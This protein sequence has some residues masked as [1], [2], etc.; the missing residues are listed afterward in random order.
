MMA[1]RGTLE[2]AARGVY[3]FPRLP[4]GSRDP[5]ML[6]VLWAGRRAHLSHETALAV[7]DLSDLVPDRVHVTVPRAARLRRSGGELYVV[8]RKD[9]HDGQ[10]TWW[11]GIPIVTVATA[12]RQCVNT[13]VPAYLLRQAIIAA[14]D[15]GEREW[16]RA[17]G[18][19]SRRARGQSRRRPD[20]RGST[21]PWLGRRP[22]LTRQSDRPQTRT[23]PRQPMTPAPASARRQRGRRDRWRPSPSEARSQPAHAS[24]PGG[25]NQAQVRAGLS[26]DRLS[27]LVAST[28]VVAALQRAVDD[29][30]TPLFL[31]K[32][33]TYLQHRLHRQGRATK[34]VDGIARG[35]RL[36]SARTLR[37][38]VARR[39][40]R[41]Q[42]PV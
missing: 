29:T 17:G 25:S 32:G 12:I 20:P 39:A 31:L 21:D 11:E 13:G 7:R 38:E 34:D 26:A 18:S 37:P 41:H 36:A 2:H 22:W 35:A 5:Y 19:A 10:T 8:H 15:R 9:L 33:G 40:A 30:G 23:P 4:A 42:C 3:R 6:A 28:V 1:S 27:W 16:R 24:S 14:D